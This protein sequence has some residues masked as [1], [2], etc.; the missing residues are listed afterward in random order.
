MG[1]TISSYA[2][3]EQ[4]VFALVIDTVFE[5]LGDKDHCRKAYQSAVKRIEKYGPK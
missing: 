3:K 5:L 2:H 1:H 4:P